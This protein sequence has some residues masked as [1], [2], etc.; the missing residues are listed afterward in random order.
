V[1]LRRETARTNDKIPHEL[2]LSARARGIKN[3]VMD[4]ES[5]NEQH[6]DRVF[7]LFTL[8]PSY[9]M[10]VEGCLPS[11]GTARE[12]IVGRPSRTLESYRKEFLLIKMDDEVIG[13]VELHADH[14]EPYVAYIGLLVIREDLQGRELGRRSYAQ[15]EDYIRRR[16]SCR[17]VRLGVSDDNDVSGFWSK[18]GFAANGHSY[19]WIGERKVTNVIEYEKVLDE[20][21][22]KEAKC[23]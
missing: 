5:V 21:E 9:F 14:P 10:N 18:M 15:V 13:G 17:R 8:A 7:D 23:D 2:D 19:S 6:Q 12:A 16:F 11:P 1:Y 4:L 3:Q 22:D 20:V